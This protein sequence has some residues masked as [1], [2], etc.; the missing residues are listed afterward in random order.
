MNATRARRPVADDSVPSV[1]QTTPLP[2]DWGHERDAGHIWSAISDL[3]LK[4]GELAGLVASNQKTLDELKGLQEDIDEL[5]LEQKSTAKTIKVVGLVA[6]PLIALVAFIAP[7]FWSNSMR[8]E[9]ERSIGAQVK[10][11]L[12]KEQAA[13]EKTRQLE[14]EISELKAQLK[15]KTTQ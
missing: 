3:K 15:A 10:S 9:L 1:P 12:E 8:P 7:Y 2:Q 6:T 4:A 11:D 5:K 14:T 13:R